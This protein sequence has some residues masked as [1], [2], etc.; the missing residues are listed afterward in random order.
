MPRSFL[1][2]GWISVGSPISI[3]VTNAAFASAAGDSA[4]SSRTLSRP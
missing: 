2:A 3:A 1:F 4:K